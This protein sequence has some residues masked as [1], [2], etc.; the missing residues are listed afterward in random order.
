MS[1]FACYKKN[2]LLK[3]IVLLFVLTLSNAV[4]ANPLEDK[5]GL[6]TKTDFVPPPIPEVNSTAFKN[7]VRKHHTFPSPYGYEPYRDKNHKEIKYLLTEINPLSPYIPVTFYCNSWDGCPN[8]FLAT[9]GNVE[10]Y[11][12]DN[13]NNAKLGFNSKLNLRRFFIGAYFP[14]DPQFYTG[15]FLLHMYFKKIEKGDPIVTLLFSQRLL[16]IISDS[17]KGNLLGNITANGK[18]IL[19]PTSDGK[20]FLSVGTTLGVIGLGEAS[21]VE[22]SE[23]VSQTT[24]E[25]FTTQVQTGFNINFGFETQVTVG[26]GIYPVADSIKFGI[27]A[28]LSR[29]VTNGIQIANQQTVSRTYTIKPGINETYYWAIY[30]LLYSYRVNAPLLEEVLKNAQSIWDDRITFKIADNQVTQDGKLIGSPLPPQLS[31]MA[32]DITVGVAVPINPNSSGKFFSQRI[33]ASN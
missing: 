30:Q 11:Y 2:F 27:N 16:Q 9:N 13:R 12:R 29:M 25:T 21:G 20:E 15:D 10:F 7:Y 19:L 3:T 14:D 28:T 17:S 1:I 6:R 4:I 24:G 18:D 22:F 5:R 31:R 32:N 26:G 23:T 33:I 8:F